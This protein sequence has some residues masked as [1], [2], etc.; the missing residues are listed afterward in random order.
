MRNL[1]NS[2]SFWK[3]E[4]IC[5]KLAYCFSF[6]TQ[7]FKAQNYSSGGSLSLCFLLLGPLALSELPGQASEGEDVPS[8]AGT[9][10]SRVEWYPSGVFP[11]LR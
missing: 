3:L 11:F 6:K 8:P 9:G 4:R 1:G 7:S 5:D 10:Y 2:W